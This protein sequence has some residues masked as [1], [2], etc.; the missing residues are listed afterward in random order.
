MPTVG[1]VAA[2]GARPPQTGRRASTLPEVAAEGTLGGRGQGQAGPGQG[3]EAGEP[4]G[5]GRG[6]RQAS[7]DPPPSF[8]ARSHPVSDY[9]LLLL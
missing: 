2:G 9:S 6:A 1:A 8:E 4:R 7:I 3:S 5:R